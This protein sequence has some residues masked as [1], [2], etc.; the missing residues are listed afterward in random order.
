MISAPVLAVAR[1]GIGLPQALD[2]IRKMTLTFVPRPGAILVF[3]ATMSFSGRAPVRFRR[4]RIIPLAIG[5]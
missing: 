4:A 5:G 3:R 2:S 1:V